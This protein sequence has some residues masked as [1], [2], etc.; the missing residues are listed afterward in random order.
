MGVDTEGYSL[1]YLK[2]QELVGIE[3]GYNGAI[4][5]LG[6]NPKHPR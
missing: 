2:T 5:C 3:E 4:L 6:F 1:G